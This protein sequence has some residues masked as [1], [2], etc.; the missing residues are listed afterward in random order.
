MADRYR[1]KPV[2]IEAMHWD[3]SISSIRSI[4]EWANDEADEPSV[5]YLTRPD[6]D[7][8]PHLVA[9]DVMCHTLEGPLNISPG[10][11]IFTGVQGENYPCKPDI[12]AA[13]YEEV[14]DPSPPDSN[15]DY[16]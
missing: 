9:F 7:G 8:P 10:D 13:T 12:F 14:R 15:E 3:G 1:K 11:W 5:D 6:A 2:V 16:Y 4:C